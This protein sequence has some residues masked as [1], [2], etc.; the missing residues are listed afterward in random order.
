MR[1]AASKE[2]HKVLE[3]DGKALLNESSYAPLERNVESRESHRS[4][5]TGKDGR[6]AHLKK[7]SLD[8]STG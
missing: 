4:A 3:P 7:E 1:N 5:G 2:W 8:Q 6:D